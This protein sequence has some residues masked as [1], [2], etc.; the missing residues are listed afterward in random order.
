MVAKYTDVSDKQYRGVAAH[1]PSSRVT[2]DVG[3]QKDDPIGLGEYGQFYS[4]PELEAYHAA[5]WDPMRAAERGAITG[6]GDTAQA[7]LDAP[8]KATMAM[9]S[10]IAQGMAA[11]SGGAG[12][13]PAGGGQAAMLRQAGRD[14][15]ADEATFM[16]ETL[17]GL[18]L[19]A[20]EAYEKSAQLQSDISNREA[21]K[22]IEY[23]NQIAALVDQ[24]SNWFSDDTEAMGEG[25]VRM[26]QAEPDPAVREY[27]MNRASQIWSQS[28]DLFTKSLGGESVG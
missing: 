15:G 18:Q 14:Y 5:T 20:A 2:P 25:I 8:G 13:A 17:P 23:E 16:S 19:G 12:A 1:A 9:R 6:Y 7:Y 28:S 24:H 26:A 10:R 11:A 22:K 3:F 27:L 21:Q 4:T